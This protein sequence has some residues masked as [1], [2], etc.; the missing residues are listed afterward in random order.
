M[1]KVDEKECVHMHAYTMYAYGWMNV[2][3]VQVGMYAYL[4][5]DIWVCVYMLV[6]IY[7]SL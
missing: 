1:K 7:I 3:N 5:V 6:C 2:Y 4:D